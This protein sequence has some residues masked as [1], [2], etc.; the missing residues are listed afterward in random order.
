M[1]TYGLLLFLLILPQAPWSLVFFLLCFLL[2]YVDVSKP[3]RIKCVTKNLV[4]N[5]PPLQPN[6]IWP[7]S[8]SAVSPFD[9]FVLFMKTIFCSASCNVLWEIYSTLHTLFKTYRRYLQ[10]CHP[11]L[12]PPLSCF[13]SVSTVGDLASN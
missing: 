4:G 11:A 1:F 12:L 6:Q 3:G 8:F 13:A 10:P 2:Y 5:L 9:L 7:T